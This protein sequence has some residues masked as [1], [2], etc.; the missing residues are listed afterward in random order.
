MH[1]E[2]LYTGCLSE[3]SYYIDSDGEAAI[4]DPLRDTEVYTGL[5]EKRG[6]VIKFI[7]ETHF[8]ADFVSGHLD[9]AQKTGA[10]I[11]YGPGTRTGF[12]IH[13]AADGERFQVGKLT[14]EAIHTPGHTV[15]ST[16]YLLRDP[17]GR[18]HCLFTGDTLFVG[19]V[20]R[21]DLSSGDLDSE[22]LASML[23]DSLGKLKQLPDDVIIYPAHGPGSSCGKHLADATS[24][25]LGE[26][27]AHNYALLAPDRESFIQQVTAGLEPPPRYFRASAAINQKGYEALDKVV[28]EAAR[29]L[30]LADF[31]EQVAAG[32]LIVDSRSDA[33][34]AE[35]FVPGSIHIGLKGRFAEWVGM[36]IPY[37][38]PV[39]LVTE[40]GEEQET[41]IRM[42]R[43]GFERVAGYLNGGIQA[44]TG[45]PVDMIIGVEP[46][47]LA[48]DFGFDQKLQVI[49]VRKPVEFAE[50]HI[51]GARNLPLEEMTDPGSM[52][53]IS[54]YQN[55]YIHCQ[56]GY[57]SLIACSLFKRQGFHNLRNIEGGFSRIRE[58]TS[59]PV[60]KEAGVL[61]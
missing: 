1:I 2:Q 3:A 44:W 34:F 16:C 38:S 24:T 57:R 36:L 19:D 7:F 45:E 48:L 54:E 59:L 43:V 27:K 33:H 42:A 20:G 47:E 52:A 55:L 10:P 46:E 61:N 4:I 8:H 13:L 28:A 9:L 6:A 18:P 23:Y 53:A 25:T 39:V 32:A 56:S 60:V 50:G 35:A 17:E 11:V 41:I 37:E 26:Q 29:P 30:G 22:E 12:P 49:D 31:K 40:P 21:P 5:A 15:E 58:T 14:L 51:R